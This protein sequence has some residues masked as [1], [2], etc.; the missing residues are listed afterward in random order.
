MIQANELRIGNL[1]CFIDETGASP[2]YIETNV[3][4]MEI[5]HAIKNNDFF[6]GIPLTEE[7]LVRFGLMDKP[8]Y[9][10]F[11]IGSMEFDIPSM[12]G[13]CL[14]NELGLDQENSIHIQSVHQLQNLYFALTGEEL[15]LNDK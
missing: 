14:D 5:Q 15:K 6:Q 9:K 12:I 8:S 3:G 2:D 13:G 7:W 11:H 4:M 10:A 1:V